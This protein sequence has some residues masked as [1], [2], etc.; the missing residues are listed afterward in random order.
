MK[1]TRVMWLFAR[2]YRKRQRLPSSPL[3]KTP[4]TEFPFHLALCTE[5]FPMKASDYTSNWSFRV[6]DCGPPKV[7]RLERLLLGG[8]KAP[9]QATLAN[10]EAAADGINK[11][12]SLG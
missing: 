3:S 7:A 9:N 4:R 2:S 11:P 10:T 12:A 1:S 5:A 8:S 6:T